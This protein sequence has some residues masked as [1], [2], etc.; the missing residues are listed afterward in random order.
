MAASDPIVFISRSRVKPDK[1]AALREFL[2]MGSK[3][4]AEAK[5]NTLAFLAYLD[6]PETTLTIIHVFANADALDDHVGGAGER[7]SAAGEFI[8]TA[9]MTVYGSATDAAMTAIRHG[10]PDTVPVDS[11][12]EYVAG[13]L[14][15]A[16]PSPTQSDTSISGG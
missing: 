6:E 13:F 10:L 15:L 3:G 12:A 4:L 2:A 7:S 8:E 16:P 14:R 11:G 1:A 5:P 9:A